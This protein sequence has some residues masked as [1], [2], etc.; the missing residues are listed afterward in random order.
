MSWTLRSYEDRDLAGVLSSWENASRLAHP[1]VS[2]EFLTRERDRIPTL[3]LPAGDTWVA[4]LDGSVVGFMTLIGNEV[5]A[6]FVEPH[7]HGRGI[8]R[9]LLDHARQLHGDLDVEVFER[10]EIGRR[11]YARY[12]FQPVGTKVHDETGEV[13]LCLRLA[14]GQTAQA[15]SREDVGGLR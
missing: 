12:G 11:F 2:E 10:N 15:S 6:V 7:L 1:F 4:E 13:V 5:G 3:F 14:G 8:G 9:S